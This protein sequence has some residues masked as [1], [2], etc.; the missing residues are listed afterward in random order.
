MET[1]H[2]MYQ[3]KDEISISHDLLIWSLFAHRPQ[4]A[5]L[6]WKTSEHQLCKYSLQTY[7]QVAIV[8]TSEH[9]LCK[10]SLQ[11]YNQVAIV[12]FTYMYECY[13]LD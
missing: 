1:S 9:Q 3:C 5:T 7:N 2:E 13:K 11:T 6:F 10:Y 8:K 4:L 12:N